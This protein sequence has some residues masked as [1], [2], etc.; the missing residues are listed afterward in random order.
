MFFMDDIQWF[1]TVVTTVRPFN[2]LFSMILLVFHKWKIVLPPILCYYWISQ[3]CI[4]WVTNVHVWK[5]VYFHYP[6]L[7]DHHIKQFN[8]TSQLF[9]SVTAKKLY[10][11]WNRIV[12]TTVVSKLPVPAPKIN[13]WTKNMLCLVIQL[14][15]FSGGPYVIYE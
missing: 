13:P 9:A 15:F 11:I 8:V 12:K 5:L 4:S 14:V 7:M 6:F 3:I 1:P 10:T 2:V